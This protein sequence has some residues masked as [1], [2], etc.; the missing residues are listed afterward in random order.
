[1]LIRRLCQRVTF[2]STHLHDRCGTSPPGRRAAW[3]ER[4][5]PARRAA[6]P[7][8]CTCVVRPDSS[9]RAVD[10]RSSDDVESDKL[11]TASR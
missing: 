11:R 8:E 5:G 10:E 9:R 6:A 2:E 7:Y 1:M 4:Q 3:R